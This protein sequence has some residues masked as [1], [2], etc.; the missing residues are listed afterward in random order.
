MPKNRNRDNLPE[1]IIGTIAG[2]I[3]GAFL[4]FFFFKEK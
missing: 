3:I 4:Y 2:I 1:V